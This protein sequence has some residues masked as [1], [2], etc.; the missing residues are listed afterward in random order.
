MIETIIKHKIA[1]LCIDTLFRELNNN[2][3][4]M[5]KDNQRYRLING[6]RYEF[7][8]IIKNFRTLPYKSD[9]RIEIW[10]MYDVH[11]YKRMYVNG[12]GEMVQVMASNAICTNY[13]TNFN[14]T[15]SH[16][17]KSLLMYISESWITTLRI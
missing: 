4:E 13:D 15:R 6:H 16:K 10:Y 14:V 7:I 17:A 8:S 5:I 12:I 3:P 9:E 1:E 2:F 11:A